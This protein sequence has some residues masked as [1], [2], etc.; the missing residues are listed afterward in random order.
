[1]FLRDIRN[2]GVGK[3]AGA[4]ISSTKYD[5]TAMTSFFYQMGWQV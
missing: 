2:T 1:M 4:E 3:Y 5:S